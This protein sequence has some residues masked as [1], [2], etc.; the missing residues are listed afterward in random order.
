MWLGSSLASE[1]AG[2]LAEGTGYEDLARLGASVLTGG[3]PQLRRPDPRTPHTTRYWNDLLDEA[4][5]GIAKVGE[6][7]P[8]RF[9]DALRRRTVP[10]AQAKKGA[11]LD[12][13]AGPTGRMT[14]EGF[15]N[16]A[17]D[18]NKVRY[19]SP[20]EQA[21]IRRAGGDDLGERTS[22]WVERNSPPPLPFPDEIENFI[23]Y[24][25]GGS[26]VGRR[27]GDSVGV[28]LGVPHAAEWGTLIGGGVGALPTLSRAS[29]PAAA[30]LARAISNRNLRNAEREIRN[31]VRP[32]ANLAEARQALVRVLLQN[33]AIRAGQ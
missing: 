21:A 32:G 11:I 3:R 14:P 10:A 33:E 27:I 31:G 16:L 2:K 30:L 22:R 23:K 28:L 6:R 29:G 19:F 18:P 5:A 13:A 15:R 20:S 12:E 1:T 7:D 9:A 17:Q 4:E 8:E 24:V 25:G 26:E